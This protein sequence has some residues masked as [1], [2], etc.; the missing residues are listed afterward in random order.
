MFKMLKSQEDQLSTSYCAPAMHPQNQEDSD[1]RF[2]SL[3]AFSKF[4]TTMKNKASKCKQQQQSEKTPKS[5]KY[6][7]LQKRDSFK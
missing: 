4:V 7:K 6:K 1:I 2:G 5:P 3:S